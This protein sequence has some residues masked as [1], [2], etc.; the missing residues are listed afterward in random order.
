MRT[1]PLNPMPDGVS[2]TIKANYQQSGPANLFKIGGT[3][4]STGVIQIYEETDKTD[5]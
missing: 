2:R 4:A 3:F 5:K 1:E